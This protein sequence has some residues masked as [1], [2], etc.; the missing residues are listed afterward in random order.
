[1]KKIVII[2]WVLFAL[3]I[4]NLFSINAFYNNFS[5]KELYE[6]KDF[7]WALNYFGKNKD[8]IWLYNLWNLNYKLGVQEKEDIKK[9]NYWEKSLDYYKNSLKIKY[10]KDAEFNYNFVKEKLD[11]LNKKLEEQ[12]KKQ[13]ENKNQKQDNQDKKNWNWKDGNKKDWKT[14]ENDKQNWNKDSKNMDWWEKNQDWKSWENKDWNQEKQWENKWWEANKDGSQKSW[15]EESQ[16]RLSETAKQQLKAYEEQLKQ[17]QKQNAWSYW[18]VYREQSNP[19]D[20]FDNI[21]G[22]DPFFDNSL[23]NTWSDKKDW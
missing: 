19:F 17:E 21:F 2:L 10:S 12:K 14:W 6:N 5:W 3:L 4:I 9:I 13:E 20:S 8:Y 18:K 15:W 16:A 22:N 11:K 23:L 7:S 1:M